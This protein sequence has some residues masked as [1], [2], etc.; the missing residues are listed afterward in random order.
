LTNPIFTATDV[1][2]HRIYTPLILFGLLGTVVA[3]FPRRRVPFSAHDIVAMRFLATLHIFVILVHV[4]GTP[5]SRYSVPFR[6]LTF[7]L[8]VFFVVWIYRGYIW[9]TRNLNAPVQSQPVV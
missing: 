7:L 1:L 3:F 4:V 2:M 6:P 8:G 5:I 9:Q